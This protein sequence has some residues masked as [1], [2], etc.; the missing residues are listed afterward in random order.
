MQWQLKL[1]IGVNGLS[2]LVALFDV[3]RFRHRP[4]TLKSANYLFQI[5]RILASYTGASEIY[6]W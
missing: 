6:A 5:E 1:L 3:V 2:K 4:G